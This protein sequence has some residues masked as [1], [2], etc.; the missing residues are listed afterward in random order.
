MNTCGILFDSFQ[1]LKA[2]HMT[3]SKCPRLHFSFFFFAVLSSCSGPTIHYLG[4]SFPP[5]TEV[6]E[7]FDEQEIT[8]RYRVIGTMTNDKFIDYD[9]DYIRQ[10]MIRKAQEVGADAILYSPVEVDYDHK[11]GDRT[12]VKAKLLKFE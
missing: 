4:N 3:K 2:L 11:E 5:T 10:R 8:S 12:T 1:V 6:K 9:V 7:Y